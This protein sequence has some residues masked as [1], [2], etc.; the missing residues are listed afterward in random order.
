MG[1]SRLLKRPVP[2]LLLG[3]ESGP[4]AA[5]MVCVGCHGLGHGIRST[6][7]MAGV[8]ASWLWPWRLGLGHDI[9]CVP[10]GNPNPVGL[11]WIPELLVEDKTEVTTRILCLSL[12]MRV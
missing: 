6:V 5:V 9:L 10:P 2:S 3:R 12:N 7:V 11:E 1:N 8:Q 4:M